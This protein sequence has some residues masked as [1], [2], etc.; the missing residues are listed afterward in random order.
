[1]FLTDGLGGAI[2]L[3]AANSGIITSIFEIARNT[4]ARSIAIDTSDNLYV[5]YSG[6]II[7]QVVRLSLAAATPFSAPTGNSRWSR[8]FITTLISSLFFV[9]FPTNNF[10]YY[11]RYD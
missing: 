11:Y 10:H 7:N 2:R 4:Y 1:M 9:K 3:I 6:G 8:V 5:T